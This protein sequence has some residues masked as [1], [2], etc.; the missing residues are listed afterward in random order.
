[1]ECYKV[2]DVWTYQS[3]AGCRLFKIMEITDTLLFGTVIRDKWGSWYKT[4]L[5][6]VVYYWDMEQRTHLSRPKKPS[7][8]VKLVYRPSGK[9]KIK[10]RVISRA[11]L[12]AKLSPNISK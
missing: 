2:G 4:Q 12:E 11:D 3:Y 1:M 7:A 10:L 8:L 6:I 9:E 5:A